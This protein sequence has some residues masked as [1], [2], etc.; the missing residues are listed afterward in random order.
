LPS[1]DGLSRGTSYF[2]DVRSGDACFNDSA[3]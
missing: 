2:E 3:V 1:P